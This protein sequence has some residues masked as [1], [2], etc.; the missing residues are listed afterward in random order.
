M[1][2]AILY[3]VAIAGA[4]LVIALVNPVGGI[5]MHII[6]MFALIIHAS[7]ITKDLKHELYLSLSLVPLM[8][9][10]S[11]S[12]PLVNFPQ[13]YW[14]AVIA[15]PLLVAVFMVVRRLGY[16]LGEIGLHFNKAPY[17][18]LIA[19]TGV[20]FGI[21]EYYILKPSS[22]IASFTWEEIL[23]PAF[24]LIVCI[25]FTEELCFRGVIQHAAEAAIGQWGWLYVAVL[26][27]TMHI[28]YLSVWDG[29]FVLAVGLFFGMMV[30]K[31]GSLLGV[32]LSHGIANIV[33]YL[34][35]PFFL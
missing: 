21:A 32:T 17:Q 20:P 11:L 14:Y 22:L 27:S 15:V 12:M 2:I 16:T 7:F 13:I 28:G 6:I 34:I 33:L 24:L 26:F 31:T 9:L 25:G 10:L 35:A 29:V 19:L 8:R 23:F 4:E 3:L 18:I 5:A 1:I 30:N